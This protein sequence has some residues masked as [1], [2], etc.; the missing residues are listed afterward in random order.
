LHGKQPLTHGGKGHQLVRILEAS[1]ESLK[2]GGSPVRLEDEPSRPI[3][4]NGSAHS[5]RNGKPENG[6]FN[7]PV[8]GGQEPRVAA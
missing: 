2:H 6:K 4:K 7:I 8:S 1:S 3:A 5:G